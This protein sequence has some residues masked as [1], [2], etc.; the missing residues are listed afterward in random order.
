[1]FSCLVVCTVQSVVLLN[2]TKSTLYNWVL[3]YFAYDK[4]LK[5]SF[6]G[7]FLLQLNTHSQSQLI[8]VLSI[9]HS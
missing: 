5:Y 6:D 8:Y 4:S 7:L 9:L 1:M 2:F 3:L